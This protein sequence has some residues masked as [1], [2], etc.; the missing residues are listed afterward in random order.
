MARE[1]ITSGVTAGSKRRAAQQYGRRTI[2]DKYAAKFRQE[3]GFEVYE[4]TFRYNDLPV[5]GEDQLIL[6]IPANAAVV[7]ATLHVTEAFAGG[8]SLAV[9]LVQPGGTAVDADG[10]IT[11]ANAPLANIDA[12]G[13]YVEGSG[14]LIGGSIGANAAQIEVVATGTFTAGEATLSVKFR[15]LVDRSDDFNDDL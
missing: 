14:A 4:V 10:L 7:S 12:V 8:T 9:G 1:S 3:Q 13:D 6:R 2:E 5:H 15:P 11:D